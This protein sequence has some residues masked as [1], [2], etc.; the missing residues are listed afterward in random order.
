MNFTSLDTRYIQR[1]T[2]SWC[3]VRLLA[4]QGLFSQLLRP[5]LGKQFAVTTQSFGNFSSITAMFLWRL[6]ECLPTKRGG[7]FCT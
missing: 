6:R 3:P 1:K 4:S 7:F 5:L 2:A